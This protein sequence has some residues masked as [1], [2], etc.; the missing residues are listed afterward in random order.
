MLWN[1][2]LNVRDQQ[3][4]EIWLA[5]GGDLLTLMQ[6]TYLNWSETLKT[7]C[8]TSEVFGEKEKMNWSVAQRKSRN[9]HYQK[10]LKPHLRV[11]WSA[12]GYARGLR[13]FI[14][15]RVTAIHAI[16]FSIYDKDYGFAGTC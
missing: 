6:N 7:Q 3:M 4:K 9:G 10:Q 5:R 1:V 8:K 16:E 2:G 11:S 13:S 15:E 14:L 12:S